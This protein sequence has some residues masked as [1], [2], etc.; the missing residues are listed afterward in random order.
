MTADEARAHLARLKP[1]T[2]GDHVAAL[3]RELI[4]SGHLAPTLPSGRPSDDGDYGRMTQAALAAFLRSL[5]PVPPVPDGLRIKPHTDADGLSLVSRGLFNANRSAPIRCIVLHWP[6]FAGDARTL[7]RV[8]SRDSSG[9]S[10]HWGVDEHAA[11]EML[12][13]SARAWHATWINRWAIGIDICQAPQPAYRSRE[14]D[15]GLVLE[16]PRVNLT[17]RTAGDEVRSF[18]PLDPRIRANT[19]AL[20]RHLCDVHS[21]PRRVPMLASVQRNDHCIRDITELNAF[22]GGVVGHHHTDRG[23]SDPACWMAELFN[24]TEFTGRP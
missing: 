18:V 19:L 5:I 1:G 2:K 17:G 10:T 7:H 13:A 20:V 23:K 14:I 6:G 8:M 21:I 9:V 15:R 16:E 3:Q 22:G 11:W 12:P 24:D 4:A